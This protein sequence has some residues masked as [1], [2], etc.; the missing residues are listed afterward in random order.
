[1]IAAPLGAKIMEAG[2]DWVSS[3]RIEHFSS[4]RARR[5][6]ALFAQWCA[7]DP[8]PKRGANAWRADTDRFRRLVWVPG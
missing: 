1:M 6:I 8:G 4:S 7:A 3:E 5:S 2:R